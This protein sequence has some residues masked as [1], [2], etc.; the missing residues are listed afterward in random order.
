MSALDQVPLLRVLSSRAFLA[1]QLPLAMLHLVGEV[2]GRRTACSMDGINVGHLHIMRRR[3]ITS[4]V[5][6]LPSCC[7]SA[8]GSAADRI[9]SH[10]LL[11]RLRLTGYVSGRST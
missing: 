8:A 10:P 2:I 9:S 7:S 5:Y 11:P 4:I 3:P 6:T 1:L